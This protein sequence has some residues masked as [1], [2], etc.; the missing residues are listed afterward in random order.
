[1]DRITRKIRGKYPDLVESSSLDNHVLNQVLQ[2][3]LSRFMSS[4]EQVWPHLVQTYGEKNA[5]IWYNRWI[6]YF[7]GGSEFFGT[8]GG[9][10]NG[11][12]H[13]LFEKPET[14][15]YKV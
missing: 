15:S 8:E 12:S 7:I 5:T 4:K 13:Y 2:A 1:M 14:S 11:V 3:W 6:F 9:E 10:E